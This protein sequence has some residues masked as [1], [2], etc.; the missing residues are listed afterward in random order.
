VGE[1]I[2]EITPTPAPSITEEMLPDILE[3]IKSNTASI[4]ELYSMI[5]ADNLQMYNKM[6]QANN[7]L[8][9]IYG[10]LAVACIGLV[11]Y[12][13]YRLFRMFF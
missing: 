4:E 6:I 8:Y 7:Y 11:F 1:E 5:S 12:L 2:L 9:F 3:A 13:V 10:M